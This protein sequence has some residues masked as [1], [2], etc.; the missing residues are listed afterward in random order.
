MWLPSQSLFLASGV[1]GSWPSYDHRTRK[2]PCFAGSVNFLLKSI[3]GDPWAVPSM[4]IRLFVD[5]VSKIGIVVSPFTRVIADSYARGSIKGKVIIPRLSP[6]ELPI[7]ATLEYAGCEVYDMIGRRYSA[8]ANS[9]GFLYPDTGETQ[10]SL[11]DTS[12]S[13]GPRW[14][15]S[16]VPGCGS[17]A[18]EK[19]RTLTVPEIVQLLQDIRGLCGLEPASGETVTKVLLFDPD[20]DALKF[21]RFCN[22]A[23]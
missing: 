4:L 19:N 8:S 23:L 15:A 21:W 3:L 7:T 22:G 10:P 11:L 16:V 5:Y 17:D 6:Q 1:R 13:Y 12:E 14:A 9:I 20:S 18:L 2:L